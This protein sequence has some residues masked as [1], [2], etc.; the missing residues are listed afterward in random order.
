MADDILIPPRSSKWSGKLRKISP[1]RNS[2]ED[3]K[4]ETSPSSRD[5]TNNKSQQKHPEDNP[6]NNLKIDDSHANMIRIDAPSCSPK[7][8]ELRPE[9][10]EHQPNMTQESSESDRLSSMPDSPD[11]QSISG[12]KKSLS[13][14]VPSETQHKS[15]DIAN[16][17][18]GP[19][20]VRTY[21]VVKSLKSLGKGKDNIAHPLI[22]D[23]PHTPTAQGRSADNP[24][25][26]ISTIDNRRLPNSYSNASK[27]DRTNTKDTTRHSRVTSQ[28]ETKPGISK[29]RNNH[30]KS[31]T[32]V[33][34]RHVI[35]SAL[36]P[37]IHDQRFSTVDKLQVHSDDKINR[38][39]SALTSDDHNSTGAV[40]NKG[41]PAS[42]F[43][44]T[45]RLVTPVSSPTRTLRID[46]STKTDSDKGLKKDLSATS[47]DGKNMPQSTHRNKP[48]IETRASIPKKID[49][50]LENSD[51]GKEHNR[52]KN[53]YRE[54]INRKSEERTSLPAPESISI[55]N[56]I[57]EIN[58][59]HL[60]GKG[61]SIQR[62]SFT[63]YLPSDKERQPR[64]V[65]PSSSPGR[66]LRVEVEKIKRK[67]P[68]T[69][70]PKITKYKISP[71]FASSGSS[72]SNSDTTNR[73]SSVGNNSRDATKYISDINTESDTSSDDSPYK[74][75]SSGSRKN[76]GYRSQSGS[77]ANHSEVSAKDRGSNMRP[78][79]NNHLPDANRPVKNKHQDNEDSSGDED[80]KPE[81]PMTEDE[82]WQI[83]KVKCK[84][85]KQR[86]S[87][88][89]LHI[90][91]KRHSY[92]QAL[93]M[94]NN[95][96]QEILFTQDNLT[97]ALLLVF[98]WGSM[99]ML[100]R[101]VLKWQWAEGY[102]MAQ[103]ESFYQYD[104]LLLELG[105]RSYLAISGKMSVEMRILK[106]SIQNFVVFAI[107]KKVLSKDMLAQGVDF[108]VN[109]GRRHGNESHRQPAAQ[110]S[111]HGSAQGLFGGLFGKVLG[112][113]FGGA[114]GNSSKDNIDSGGESAGVGNSILSTLLSKVL[115]DDG[116]ILGD[117]M[118]G[119]S[120]NLNTNE[121]KASEFTSFSRQ[122]KVPADVPDSKSNRTDY[123]KPPP[124][125][126]D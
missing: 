105:E 52:L 84:M 121:P 126:S 66:R 54:K 95:A 79:I 16:D 99:E 114:P 93:R 9:V 25:Q 83:L 44:H 3:A 76:I 87:D 21:K 10:E 96:V 123:F 112:G 117:I 15:Q 17:N 73:K 27:I 58:N 88:V 1:E 71:L 72:K 33:N 42:E 115:S 91:K 8:V 116:G 48:G 14:N 45:K 13:T 35:G 60:P 18:P 113:L 36:S 49:N 81:K 57:Q 63:E 30:S 122:D 100:A 97:A 111:T 86:K 34:S 32:K 4:D 90:S 125:Y 82:K 39:N 23:N 102:T 2:A 19:S 101:Y 41:N 75:S 85:L 74:S 7:R 107:M 22:P 92:E 124:F 40:G 51:G 11:Y 106:I 20:T 120:T 103:I 29:P 38:S 12:D 80:S 62:K 61:A 50:D 37:S 59:S 118:K 78:T 64:L 77:S 6:V 94:Y 46:I 5:I 70:P 67:R 65:I 108:L 89:I 109:L 55:S 53:R 69:P 119:F 28:S 24:N 104:V 31:D 56:T 43:D 68:T 98:T 47:D 26:Q 110:D